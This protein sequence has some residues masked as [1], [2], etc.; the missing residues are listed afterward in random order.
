MESEV[1]RRLKKE[2]LEMQGIK[3]RTYTTVQKVGLGLIMEAFPYGVFPVG[4]HEFVSKTTEEAAATLAFMTALMSKVTKG[5]KCFLWIG[6]KKMVF[7]PALS[8]YGVQPDQFLFVKT[9]NSME[10]VWML[11]Q[12]LRCD[13]LGLVIGEIPDLEPGQS[14]RLQLTVEQSRINCF[15]HRFQSRINSSNHAV[16]RWH[17]KPIPSIIDD[18]MPGVGFPAWEV[19][20]DKVRNGIPG[21]WRMQWIHQ[22]FEFESDRAS[23]QRA[24]TSNPTVLHSA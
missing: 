22:H 15:L 21:S 13:A 2:I 18:G 3:P 24:I 11:E 16:C 9:A 23:K 12:A 4:I 5:D 19:T 14:R 17:V 7:P 8:F 20:L 10:S 1:V 6:T